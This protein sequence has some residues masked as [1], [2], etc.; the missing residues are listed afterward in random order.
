MR[1]SA[2]PPRAHRILLHSCVAGAVLLD[3]MASSPARAQ[4]IGAPIVRPAVPARGAAM[5]LAA[6]AAATGAPLV[7]QW[8][9]G[10]PVV[11]RGDLDRDGQLGPPVGPAGW[12]TGHL[13]ANATGVAIIVLHV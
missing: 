13:G 1:L 2:T 5:G 12:I 6:M 7:R 11:D 4:Q 3:L 8:K 9:P 10:D